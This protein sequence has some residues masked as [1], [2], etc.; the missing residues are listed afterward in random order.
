MASLQDVSYDSVGVVLS[1]LDY[2][3]HKRLLSLKVFHAA[4]ERPSFWNMILKEQFA[5]ILA[6]RAAYPKKTSVEF[7]SMLN[8]EEFLR[9]TVVDIKN[10]RRCQNAVDRK[11]LLK[12]KFFAKFRFVFLRY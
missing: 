6:F 3:E 5:V 7:V 11:D 4:I 8:S 1:F 9:R 12:R 2:F 10:E